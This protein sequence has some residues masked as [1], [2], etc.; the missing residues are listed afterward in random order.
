MGIGVVSRVSGGKRT[1]TRAAASTERRR[2]V[3]SRKP[4]THGGP[5]GEILNWSP[6]SGFGRPQ[7][8]IVGHGS[9]WQR[10]HRHGDQRLTGPH[11]T[12]AKF[13][14]MRTHRGRVVPSVAALEGVLGRDGMTFLASM[15]LLAGRA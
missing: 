5:A 1:A 14:R 4:V 6:R 3:A 7:P 9:G 12:G 10:C 13:A 2:Q 11:R 8:I 15:P